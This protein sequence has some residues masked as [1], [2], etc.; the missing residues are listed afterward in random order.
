MEILEGKKRGFIDTNVLVF[1]N[2]SSSQFHEK[3]KEI[4]IGLA[5]TDCEL[6]I[7]NQVIREYVSVLSRPDAHG[8]KL[9]HQTLANDVRRL[10]NDYTVLFENNQTIDNLLMLVSSC[11]TGG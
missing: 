2:V 7:S 4:L 3:A 6:F 1:A 10:R 11:P 9:S 8:N 5:E